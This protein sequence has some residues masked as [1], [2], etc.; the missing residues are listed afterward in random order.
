[1]NTTNFTFISSIIILFFNRVQGFDGG[2]FQTAGLMDSAKIYLMTQDYRKAERMLNTVSFKL[3]EKK[4]A[5]YLS[6]AIK[7]TEILDYESYPLD[8]EAFL[9]HADSVS[10]ELCH[11][12]PLEKGRD[13]LKCMFYIGST[14]GGIGIIQARTGNWPFGVRNA[15]ASVGYFKQVLKIDPDFKAAYLG[16]GIF[17]YY[18][19]DNFKWLPFFGD[20]RDDAIKQIQAATL[21][22]FP[23][24][25]A[26]CNS[27]CWIL[28]ERGQIRMADSIATQVL[29]KYPD[30]TMFIRIKVRTTLAKNQW[31]DA[32][33]LA[34]KLIDLSK[35]RNPENWSDVLS[36]Y[37]AVLL[38]YDKLCLKKECLDTSDKVLA[39]DIPE[40]FR[41]IQ[42]VKKHLKYAAEIRKKYLNDK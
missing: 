35:K 36:G 38:S 18:F 28:L 22:P 4:E 11:R 13:S 6:C 31:K 26:A 12:L 23:Y 14:L 21:A 42:Y 41:K 27:F 8:G 32:I 16:I 5:L 30:N 2:S 37:Q 19:S 1:M 33:S 10:K 3:P 20:K 39:M 9:K 7:Q 40:R 24:N 25:Y 17:N 34:Q 15:M 29:L